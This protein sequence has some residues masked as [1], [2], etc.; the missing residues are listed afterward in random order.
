[1]LKFYYK[2]KEVFK[3]IFLNL[4]S[5]ILLMVFIQLAAFPY[6]AKIVNDIQ[7]GQIIALYGIN[8]AIILFLGNSLN[9]LRLLNQDKGY[10]FR[11]LE[12]FVLVLSTV[13]MSLFG[14][15]YGTSLDILT[16][17]TF[18]L[19]TIMANVRAYA[20]VY[21]RIRLQYKN[22]LYLNLFILIGSIIGFLFTMFTNFWSSIF[23][24]GEIAG[25][26]Y[27]VKSKNNVFLKSIKIEKV[28]FSKKIFTQFLSLSGSNGLSSIFN[29]LDRFI[30]APLL[31]ASSMGVF[32]AA[33][34]VS[35]II[36]MVI[37]P[38]SNVMLSYISVDRRTVTKK[39]LMLIFTIS[40][41]TSIPLY[42]VLNI[43]S[44]FLTNILY[45]NYSLYA[46][47]LIPIVTIGI[48]ANIIFNIIN[49]FILKKYSIHFQFIIQFTYGSIYF[50]LAL[51]LG[52]KYGIT[53]FTIAY[54]FSLIIKLSIQFLIIILN[55]K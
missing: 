46:M 47:K 15:L 10:D 44:K 2:Y 22:I 33:S 28:S 8:N 41:V 19:F 48:L 14:Y 31:G 29:Y 45:P 35:K 11:F 32:Y 6:I 18:V 39:M 25:I 50:I 4:V 5:N 27:Q 53:G 43:V 17:I 1:M 42:Y 36:T 51:Y 3:D 7:F 54:T 21:Y 24:F 13:L 12:L 16:V 20:T 23:L 9:N 52:T 26:V 49:P 34:S 55:K 37:M 40:T 30:I 38:M